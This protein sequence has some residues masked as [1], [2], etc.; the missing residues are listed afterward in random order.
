MHNLSGLFVQV[1][2]QKNFEGKNYY[3]FS[4][5]N[6]PEGGNTITVNGDPKWYTW[7]S[8]YQAGTVLDIGLPNG[9]SFSF[10]MPD[11]NVVLDLSEYE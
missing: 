6:I 8:G 4:V 10:T 7:S 5:T 11:H 9:R 3:S 2:Q 1:E